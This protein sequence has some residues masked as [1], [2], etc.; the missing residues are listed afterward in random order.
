MSTN[1]SAFQ[2][3]HWFSLAFVVFGATF[4]AYLFIVYGISKLGATITGTYVYTQPVFATLTAMLLFHE[5]L[6]LTKIIAAILI[7]CGVFIAN[8]KRVIDT[9]VE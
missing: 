9:V 1:W 5:E 2:F 8:K 3:S 7:F 6:N 4:I